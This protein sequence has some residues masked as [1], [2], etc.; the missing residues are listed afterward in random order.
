MS[1]LS[2]RAVSVAAQERESAETLEL[3]AVRGIENSL[4]RHGCSLS[5]R[6]ASRKQQEQL[7]APFERSSRR[8]PANP[9]G[10]SRAGDKIGVLSRQSWVSNR[11]LELANH[12]RWVAALSTSGPLGRGRRSTERVAVVAECHLGPRQSRGHGAGRSVSGRCCRDRTKR[13]AIGLPQMV[14]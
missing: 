6:A 7:G 10:G 5:P 13:R 8:K 1:W 4:P 3:Y 9:L 12:S 14:A 2:Q 11:W